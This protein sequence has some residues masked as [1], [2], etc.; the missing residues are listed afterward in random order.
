MQGSLFKSESADPQRWRH[1]ATS[2]SLQLVGILLL[3]QIAFEAPQVITQQRHYESI[4]LYLNKPEPEPQ[5]MM[6]RKIAPP[7]PAVIKRITPPKVELP[8]KDIAPPIVAKL[9]PPK[10]LP[11]AP[12]V[13]TAHFDAPPVPEPKPR[14]NPTRPIELGAFSGSSATPTIKAPVREVQT[15]GFGDPN[16][17]A[18]KPTNDHPALVAA[19]VGAFDLPQGRGYGNGSGGEHGRPGVVASAG[20]GDGV[21]GPGSGTRTSGGSHRVLACLGVEGL[22]SHVRAI[23]PDDGCCLR[24]NPYL[25]EESRVAKRLENAAPART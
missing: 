14:G 25:R 2:Y 5:H 1:F 18:G 22:R 19:R 6:V 12:K 4:Q 8:Q 7:P 17:I 9:E 13:E 10:P 3:T 21:A 11:P 16:G 20:F 15:G 24:I 23:G